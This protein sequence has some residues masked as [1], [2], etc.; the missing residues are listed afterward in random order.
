MLANTR[1]LL[2]VVVVVIDTRI[3][4]VTVADKLV[5]LETE[6]YYVDSC[7]ELQHMIVTCT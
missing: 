2:H 7:T 4:I 5:L 3:E 1:S 6:W